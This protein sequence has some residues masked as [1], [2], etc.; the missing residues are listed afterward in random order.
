[1]LSV[2]SSSL[3]DR[4]KLDFRFEDLSR[5]RGDV[6]RLRLGDSSPTPSSTV[7]LVTAGRLARSMVDVR[8]RGDAKSHVS[9][10]GG[11]SSVAA[12]A[13]SASAEADGPAAAASTV[14]STTVGLAVVV[15]DVA[16]RLAVAG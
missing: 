6:V 5:S 12:A 14:V 13:A 8:Q 4:F 11:C 16:V 15:G 2:A 3:S 9:S 10:S 1:M 7:R